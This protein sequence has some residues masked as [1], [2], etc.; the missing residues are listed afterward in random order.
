VENLEKWSIMEGT[1]LA[2]ALTREHRAID[3][4]IEAFLAEPN[5]PEPLRVAMEALRRHIY[6]EEQFLFPPLRQ[7]MMMPVF[8]M[9]REHGEL[10]RAMDEVGAALDAG[11]AGTADRC[12]SLLSLLDAHNAKEEPVVY[13]RADADLSPEVAELLAA[14]LADGA[15]PPGWVCETA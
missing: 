3:A 5:D 10:W 11:D 9:L 8:V 12:R 13:P 14:F 15:Y 7:S 1:Q 6:L 2:D 4:G